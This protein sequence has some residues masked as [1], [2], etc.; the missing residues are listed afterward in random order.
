MAKNKKGNHEEFRPTGTMTILLI[1]L[2]TLIVLW[3]TIYM[4]LLARGV[5]L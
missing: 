2:V 4:I 3:V 5:T 1:F